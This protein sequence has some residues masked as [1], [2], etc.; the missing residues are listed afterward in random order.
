MRKPSPIAATLAAVFALALT[1]CAG[2]AE[3]REDGCADIA[4]QY[5]D[6]RIEQ[7]SWDIYPVLDSDH[8]TFSSSRR[9]N[10]GYSSFSGSLTRHADGTFSGDGIYRRIASTDHERNDGMLSKGDQF[11]ELLIEDKFVVFDAEIYDC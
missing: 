4:Y 1:G 2:E 7:G 11:A 9:L 5:E 8:Y 10:Y 3:I 6:G